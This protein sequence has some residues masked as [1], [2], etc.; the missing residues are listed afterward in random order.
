MGVANEKGFTLLEILAALVITVFIFTAGYKLI[1][2]F[3]VDTSMVLDEAVDIYQIDAY[4]KL[5]INDLRHAKNLQVTE[6][7]GS[8]EV[9][10]TIVGKD[11]EILFNQVDD[12]EYMLDY[13]DT[14]G[15]KVDWIRMETPSGTAPITYNEDKGVVTLNHYLGGIPYNYEI[16]VRRVKDE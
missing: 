10:Y 3:V 11:K 14:G 2:I 15:R 6:S 9:S 4:N 13:Y 1:T 8:I 5:F 16:H 12:F 7:A